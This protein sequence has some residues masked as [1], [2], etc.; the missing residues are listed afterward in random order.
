MP[1]LPATTGF[2]PAF[3]A[4]FVLN[5]VDA[6]KG[7]YNPPLAIKR[8]AVVIQQDRDVPALFDLDRGR[9]LPQRFRAG[10]E[11]RC[12]PDIG[13]PNRSGQQEK[14]WKQSPSGE[15]TGATD[16]THL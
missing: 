13:R 2:S 5:S 9:R 15:H 4:I 16:Q 10:R 3:H 8:E 12:V 14:K 6:V 11:R 7:L 1:G